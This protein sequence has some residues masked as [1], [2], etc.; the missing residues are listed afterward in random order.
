MRIENQQV[1]RLLDEKA[2]RITV[3]WRAQE[4]SKEANATECTKEREQV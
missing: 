3:K 2:R 4:E 1:E